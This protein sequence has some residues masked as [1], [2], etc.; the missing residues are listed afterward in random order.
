MR[1]AFAG[2]TTLV[3]TRHKGLIVTLTAIYAA[4]YVASVALPPEALRPYFLLQGTFLRAAPFFV[5]LILF[6]TFSSVATIDLA[7]PESQFHRHLFALPV[8]ASQTVL[9]FMLAAI[10][11][12]ALLWVAGTVITDGRLMYAGPPHLPLE[13]LRREDWFPFMQMSLLT[14]TQAMLWMSFSRKWT[15]VW[16]L[17]ALVF[18]HAYGLVLAASRTVSGTT[19]LVGCAI[20]V[21]LAF[22][23][24]VWGVARA[25]RGDPARAEPR[26]QRH[27]LNAARGKPF[28]SGMAA[29]KWLEGRI[30][31]TRGTMIAA[32][33]IPVTVLWVAA[34]S[35][36]TDSPVALSIVA[37]G[38]LVLIPGTLCL[39]SAPA[40]AS[41]QPSIAW[42][43]NEAFAM[44]SYFAALPLGTGDFA[45]LKLKTAARNM[46]WISGFVVLAMG[47]VIWLSHAAPIWAHFFEGLG[48]RFG[49]V[50]ATLMLCFAAL[51]F[52][53]VTT[54][55][56]ASM[57][58]IA[59]LGRRW[60]LVGGLMWAVALAVVVF[61]P[62]LGR[63]PQW[64]AEALPILKYVWC[65][66]AVVKVIALA[67][68]VRRV[69]RHE[70][71]PRSRL[72][73][74]CACWVFGVIATL[75]VYSRLAQQDL[76]HTLYALCTIIVVI[77]VL[78]ILAAPLALQRNRSR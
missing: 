23:I 19:A 63:R 4:L 64:L 26:F 40:F 39:S 45:W 16:A 73:G 58:W 72:I 21:P 47:L 24:A 76:E 11:V 65:A 46:L 28:P 48:N 29:Q 59:L 18:A 56:T 15:R 51:D 66:I 44:P 55:A 69:D 7:T 61:V 38:V 12:L 67:E 77:P 33:A 13:R 60:N 14:W 57:V 31:R 30:H 5:P 42:Y 68:L 20:Q 52:M 78:G 10:L 3:W 70:L 25:R 50:E 75:L 32:I 53:A 41:F 49:E 74:I 1:A 35:T 71:Y 62:M 22:S 54:A 8:T 9:P 37:S 36:F 43:R 17:L 6:V 2:V 34:S 27:R